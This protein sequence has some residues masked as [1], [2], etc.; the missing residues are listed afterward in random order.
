[1]TTP[2]FKA[3]GR[4]EALFKGALGLTTVP[5]LLGGCGLVSTNSPFWA[6]VASVVPQDQVAP[7]TRAQASALPYASVLAWF[8]EAP[9]AFLV[10]GE[11]LEGRGLAWYSSNRQIIVTNGP[12]I[13]KTAG[14]PTDV[15]RV[16]F[17]R[18]LPQGAE[19]FATG[20][21]RRADIPQKRLFDWYWRSRFTPV[22]RE[23]VTILDLTFDLAVFDERIEPIGTP[24]WTNRYWID[25]ASGFCW[26]SRQT[27]VPG[28]PSINL[29][30]VKPF[31]AA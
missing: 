24:G 23:S 21:D 20:I 5:A 8:D 28:L 13:V 27:L 12:F 3:I 16:Q 29:E 17:D 7:V 31:Q 6:T 19:V 25:A 10:L 4:R 9:K 1:M 30:I 18:P 2:P 14:M 11:I 15:N 26:K 22:G